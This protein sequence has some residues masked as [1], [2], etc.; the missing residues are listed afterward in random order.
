MLYRLSKADGSLV[1]RTF[2]E[3]TAPEGGTPRATDLLRLADGRLVVA[4]GLENGTRGVSQG[5]LVA[6][7]K[8]GTVDSAFG[9]NGLVLDKALTTEFRYTTAFGR[10]FGLTRTA[11]GYALTAYKNAAR[12][13]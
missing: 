6:Y 7:Q 13:D 5:A 8:S 12:R 4:G 3:V 11:D 1:S 9:Q 2:R 10:I